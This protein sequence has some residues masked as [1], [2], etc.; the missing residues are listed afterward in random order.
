MRQQGGY[1][2]IRPHRCQA[3]L[4]EKGK[5]SMQKVGGCG[6]KTCKDRSNIF[7]DALASLE[8][9]C[10]SLLHSV[11]FFREILDQSVN[12]TSDIQASRPY[13]HTTLQLNNITTLQ[14]KTLQPYNLTALQPYSL[15]A[16]QPYSLT[17]LQ[18]IQ[19]YK[20]TTL[21]Q[22]DKRTKGQKDKRTKRQ[23]EQK[24]IF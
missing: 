16:S 17:T 13:I 9:V 3:I 8:S 4:R 24:E 21:Q 23:N 5:I 18:L 20:L 2:H 1:Q 22:K 14:V 19:P 15:T 12:K 7:L 11:R 6:V 10:P